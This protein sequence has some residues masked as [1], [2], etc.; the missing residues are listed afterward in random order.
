MAPKKKKKKKPRLGDDK[1]FMKAECYHGLLRFFKYLLSEE[2]EK[3]SSL[4]YG[5]HSWVEDKDEQNQIKHQQM[6]QN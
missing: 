2:M 1:E 5:L 4:T 6:A 3:T